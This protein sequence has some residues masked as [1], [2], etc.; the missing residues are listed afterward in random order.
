MIP[1]VDAAEE[2]TRSFRST[3][4]V[5]GIDLEAQRVNQAEREEI[6]AATI[7]FCIPYR[8]TLQMMTCLLSGVQL[9]MRRRW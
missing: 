3:R 7:N 6:S 4:I 2:A 8:T 5:G 9:I 1:M